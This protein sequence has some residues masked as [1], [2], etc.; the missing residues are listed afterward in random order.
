MLFEID[1]S[2]RLDRHFVEENPAQT[3]ATS[4]DLLRDDTLK[5]NKQIE[6]ENSVVVRDRSVSSGKGMFSSLQAPALSGI[7]AAADRMQ[8]G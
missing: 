2:R 7:K 8:D 3:P 1:C 4:A 6:F 5:E